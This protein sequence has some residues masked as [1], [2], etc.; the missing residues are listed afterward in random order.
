MIDYFDHKNSLSFVKDKY[1][2][3]SSKNREGCLQVCHI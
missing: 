2:I 3:T 1:N